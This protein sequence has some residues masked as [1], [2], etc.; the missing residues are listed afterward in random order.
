[1]PNDADSPIPERSARSRVQ[2]RTLTSRELDDAIESLHGMT[3]LSPRGSIEY[4]TAADALT[5]LV[6]L[7][8]RREVNP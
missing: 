7:R 2:S 8:A 1:M 3:R 6:E 4:R 5:G